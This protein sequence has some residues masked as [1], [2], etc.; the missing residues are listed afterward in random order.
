VAREQGPEPR[1]QRDLGDIPDGI[2]GRERPEREV[3]PKNGRHH[4]QG[5]EGNMRSATKLESAHLAMGDPGSVAHLALHQAGCKT[6]LAKF[7]TDAH[8]GASCEASTRVNPTFPRDHGPRISL[9]A[10]RRLGAHLPLRW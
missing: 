4:R 5:L 7:F 9:V 2:A 6:R 8:Q 1:E 3:E 10:A